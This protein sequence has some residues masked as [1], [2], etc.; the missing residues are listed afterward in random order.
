[1][2]ID[3][4]INY[5]IESAEVDFHAMNNLYKSKDYMWALFPGHLVIEKL[6]K[7]LAAKNQMI[8]IPKIHEL[9]KLSNIAGLKINES[10]K[11][12]PDKIT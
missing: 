7:G 8:N 10:L 2:T 11:D 12:T 6:I 5:W 4:Q 3:D 9:N 1:L